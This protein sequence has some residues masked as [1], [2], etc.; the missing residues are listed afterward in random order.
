MHEIYRRNLENWQGSDNEES[1]SDSDDTETDPDSDE[2]GGVPL[3]VPRSSTECKEQSVPELPAESDFDS[4]PQCVFIISYNRVKTYVQV[5][6][7][8]VYH[9]SSILKP[10]LE[11]PLH[12]GMPI[13]QTYVRVARLTLNLVNRPRPFETLR[14]FFARTS[15]TWQEIVLNNVRQDG[16]VEQ[17]MKELRKVA[18]EM[19]EAIWW[20]SREEVTALEDEQEQ[21]GIGDVIDI[22]ERHTEVGGTGRRR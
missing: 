9:I 18:F 2:E 16:P 14:D 10:R 15:T 7:C 12:T 17:S 11:G 6:Y 21:A 13:A 3:G 22:A 4:R 1:E 19:S 20:D 5:S 8:P